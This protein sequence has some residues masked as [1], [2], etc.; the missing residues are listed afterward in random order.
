MQEATTLCPSLP[1]AGQQRGEIG[2]KGKEKLSED[3]ANS[4]TQQWGNRFLRKGTVQPLLQLDAW[5]RDS[6]EVGQPSKQ[7]CCFRGA[8]SFERYTELVLGVPNNKNQCQKRRGEQR[9]MGPGWWALS[10][11]TLTGIEQAGACPSPFPLPSRL[12]SASLV[13]ESEREQLLNLDHGL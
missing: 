7:R 12:P 6:M 8:D 4:G 10:K 1:R 2:V 11:A 13:A 9:V 3:S 5:K